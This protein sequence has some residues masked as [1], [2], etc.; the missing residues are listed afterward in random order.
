M[1]HEIDEPTRR[2]AKA[3]AQQNGESPDYPIKLAEGFGIPQWV[4]YV[5]E[6]RKLIA[7]HQAMQGVTFPKP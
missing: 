2:V 5:S 4:M 3:L 6:A 1:A 7:Q